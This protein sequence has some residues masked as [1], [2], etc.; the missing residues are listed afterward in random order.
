MMSLFG[1]GIPHFIIEIA[2]LICPMLEIWKLHLPLKRKLAVAAMFFSG[3]LVCA[4]ALM[5]IIHTLTLD[6]KIDKDLTWDGIEDQVWAVCDVNL[7]SLASESI[8]ST[9]P[10]ASD[11]CVASLPLLRPVFRSFGGLFST[12]KATTTPSESFKGTGSAPTYGSAPS[13]R[14][15]ESHPDSDSEVGFADEGGL[16]A[17]N[18]LAGSSKAFVMHDITPTDSDIE[19]REQKGIHVKN[20]TKIVYHDA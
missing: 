2:I 9:I 14:T 6:K 17:G 11:N 7:A 1:A 16:M 12:V 3:F 18:D 15:R 4:S 20:E 5:T 8:K 10:S 13:K 19:R